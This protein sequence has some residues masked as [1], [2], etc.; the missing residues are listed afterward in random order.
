[1]HTQIFD[2]NNPNR[3][4]TI[5]C[6]AG[7]TLELKFV[8]PPPDGE[9]VF[10]VGM[11]TQSAALVEE[12]G[13]DRVLLDPSTLSSIPEGRI[14]KYNLWQRR[15]GTLDLV[16][17]GRLIL[18]GSVAPEEVSTQLIANANSPRLL[19]DGDSVM[20]NIPG[21]RVFLE[22]M[23]GHKF[24]FPEGYL[25]AVG[26][27]SAQD[28]YHSAPDL[29]ARIDP[30]KTVVL[31]GPVGA[32]QTA[33]D[34]GFDEITTYLNAL[35]AGYLSAGAMVVAVPTLLDGMGVTTQDEKK[36]ALAEWV[37]AFGSGGSVFYDGRE[38]VLPKHDNFFAVDVSGF[39]RDSMK[40]DVSHPN[41]A[42]SKYLAE[43]ISDTVMPLV[44]GAVY[45]AVESVNLIEVG[46]DFEGQ[47]GVTQTGV[48]GQIPSDWDVNRNEG[49]ADWVCGFDENGDFEVSIQ[50]AASDSTLVLTMRDVELDAQAGDVVNFVVESELVE[51]GGLKSIGVSGQGTSVMTLDPTWAAAPGTY[52]LRTRDDAYDTAQAVQDFQIFVRV[53]EG[54]TVTVVFKRAAAF[55]VESDGAVTPSVSPSTFSG[56]NTAINTVAPE[57]LAYSNDNRMVTA[58]PAIAG[59]RHT[60]GADLLVGRVYFECALGA[61]VLGVGIGTDAVTA[62]SGGSFGVERCFW[63]GSVVFFSG[64]NRGMGVSLD[65]GDVVQVAV[66]VDLDLIWMRVNGTGA[67]NNDVSADPV[68]GTGGLS[69]SG[70][71]GDLYSYAGLNAVSGAA[72]TLNGSLAQMAYVVP[73]GFTPIG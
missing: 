70:L 40:S 56:W 2:F 1:M 48:T 15:G 41:S 45:D 49:S 47:R 6:A 29:L 19:V 43:A 57:E 60:R 24:R 68:M 33:A 63:S 22:Q 37:S 18:R 26:G 34:D 25:G 28:I 59:L 64:G 39:D 62:L 53:A 5:S 16:A 54:A 38:Y 9:R 14:C 32:N 44:D 10:T 4:P 27:H 42:G 12:V 3:S 13:F 50:A 31:V 52:H 23:L 72:V 7:E 58:T 69:I 21:T 73:T 65:Q 20:Q 35:Y 30:G 71:A 51:S 55:F 11:D 17:E 66:D 46:A 8:N 61:D 36:S 67:W